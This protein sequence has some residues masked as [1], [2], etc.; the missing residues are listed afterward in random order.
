[1]GWPGEQHEP[2]IND[3]EEELEDFSSERNIREYMQRKLHE[4]I[5][6]TL[7]E[8]R[9]ISGITEEGETTCIHCNALMGQVSFRSEKV[10]EFLYLIARGHS[11][12]SNRLFIKILR[13]NLDTPK[14]ELVKD[15][16]ITTLDGKCYCAFLASYTI[17]GT[18]MVYPEI[19]EGK[20]LFNQ[21]NLNC[22]GEL[23][24][25]EMA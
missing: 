18:F 8:R 11:H 6:D 19:K 1:M 10:G 25:Q 23:T 9:N 13:T 15:L 5:K 22:S 7:K 21:I 16:T 12:K 20:L 17:F 4:K 3:K 24:V 14:F 2:I